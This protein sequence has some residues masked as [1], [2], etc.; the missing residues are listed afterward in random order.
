MDNQGIYQLESLRSKALRAHARKSV[1]QS[2]TRRR[3]RAREILSRFWI[4]LRRLARAVVAPPPGAAV[5]I[6]G[7]GSRE[8]V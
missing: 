4:G 5:R 3:A 8:S 6:H 7:D 1:A 2:R